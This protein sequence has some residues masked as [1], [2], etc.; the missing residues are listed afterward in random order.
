MLILSRFRLHRHVDTLSR[1]LYLF[2]C[3]AHSLALYCLLLFSVS[4]SVCQVDGRRGRR[5][6]I[7]LSQTD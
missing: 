6:T 7:G 4:V 2:L 5:G 3:L 1:Y